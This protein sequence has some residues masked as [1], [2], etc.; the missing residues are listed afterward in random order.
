MWPPR[1]RLDPLPPWEYLF[2]DD[3]RPD[4]VNGQA[5]LTTM[6]MLASS[7]LQMCQQGLVPL[8]QLL[9]NKV[10]SALASCPPPEVDESFSDQHT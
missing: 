8:R 7:V 3:L 6:T 4:V 2:I 9:L 10:Q 5:V 1:Y